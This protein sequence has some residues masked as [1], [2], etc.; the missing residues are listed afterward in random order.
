MHIFG[1][2]LDRT[3]LDTEI[4]SLSGLLRAAVERPSQ[5]R[6]VPGAAPLARGLLAADEAARIRFLSGSPRQLRPAIE[7]KLAIDGITFDRLTLK[8]NLRNLRRGRF[9]ALRAQVGYKLPTLLADR[10]ALS[11][12][13]TETWFGDDSEKDGLIYAVY[14]GVV[15]GE[16]GAEDV[17]ELL[18]RC[19]AYPDAIEKAVR[20]IERIERA[21]AVEDIF[22]RLDRGTAPKR[23]A[24]LGSKVHPVSSWFQA[25]LVL[26]ARGRLPLEKVAD[27][28]VDCRLAE[29]PEHWL[30]LF[31]DAV[32]RRLIEVDV[33]FAVIEAL[34]PTLAP[35]AQRLHD[36]QPNSLDEFA[37]QPDY[38]G[39]LDLDGSV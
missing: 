38:L 24:R 35:E 34:A 16:L 26:H 32:Q 3:Y 25:A 27:V 12:D 23:F 30:D 21:D 37:E 18:T 4:H 20:A 22:I 36:V 39:F 10:V 17:T 5:K 19:R 2:D 9:R 7:Q 33:A 1:W 11:V 8:D 31:A 14:A 28:A 6:T 29:T 13:T 15:A